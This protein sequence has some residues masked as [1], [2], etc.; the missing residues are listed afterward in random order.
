MSAM[1]LTLT[2]LGFCSIRDKVVLVSGA[3]TGIG[4]ASVKLLARA[5]ARTVIM[6]RNEAKLAALAKEITAQGAPTPVVVRGDVRHEASCREAVAQCLHHFGRIDV[7]VNNAAIGFP[8][9]IS[10]CSTDDYRRTMETNIDGVFF[11]TREVLN[12]MRQQK[13]GHI[14]MISSDSGAHGN[15]VAPIYTVSKYAV[16]G[17]T[18]SLRL[19]LEQWHAEG[20]HLRLSNIWPGTV[21]S[22]YWGERDVPRHTFLTC[23]EVAAFVVQVIACQ[24]MA[25]VTNLRVQQ[26]RF[27][28]DD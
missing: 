16:E 19:Q 9:E 28:R 14:V 26:F 24:P 8:V 20:A 6:A 21:N 5:G 2:D 25:N 10:T 27:E 17:L 23:E 18:A 11:L 12:P 3:S 7:L 4:R 15:P 22:D 13:T 1:D